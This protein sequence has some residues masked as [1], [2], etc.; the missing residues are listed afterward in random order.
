MYRLSKFSG[1]G[2]LRDR[3]GWEAYRLH[4]IRAA[5]LK[6]A[7][8]VAPTQSLHKADDPDDDRAI[9]C[10]VTAGSDFILTHNTD[11]LR[12]EQYGGI[13]I[14]QAADFLRNVIAQ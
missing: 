14:V 5:L 12:I 3:F 7:N 1:V 10:A 13:K 8:R 2:V 9:E 4:A 6:F 11:L